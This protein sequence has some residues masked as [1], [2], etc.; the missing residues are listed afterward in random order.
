MC[1]KEGLLSAR[2]NG[3]FECLPRSNDLFGM[4]L[5][6]WFREYLYDFPFLIYKEGRA[7]EAHILTPV[8]LFLAPYPVLA[9]DLMFGV[10]QEGKGQ[11][12]FRL[13]FFMFFFVVGADA[14]NRKSLS[15]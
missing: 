13:E 11:V 15:F 7:Q 9:D 5:A 2:S 8:Q 10:R 4:G 14:Q 3:L 1:W 12:E 6:F